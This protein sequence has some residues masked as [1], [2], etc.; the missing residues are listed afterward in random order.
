MLEYLP[1]ALKAV[2]SI[3]STMFLSNLR[4]KVHAA[5]AEDTILTLNIPTRQLTIACYSRFGETTAS[6]LQGY[7]QSQALIHTHNS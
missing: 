4:A 1:R 2:D 3:P 7:S 5:L 6:G